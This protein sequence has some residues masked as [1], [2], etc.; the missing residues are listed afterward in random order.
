MLV[1]HPGSPIVDLLLISTTLPR[2]H[3]AALFSVRLLG[4]LLHSQRYP[5]REKMLL[6]FKQFDSQQGTII[7]FKRREKSQCGRER[8]EIVCRNVRPLCPCSP[9][10]AQIYSNEAPRTKWLFPAAPVVRSWHC[11]GCLCCFTF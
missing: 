10:S 4:D 8:K 2:N 9:K 7:G 1:V 5:N 11:I 6:P 3:E